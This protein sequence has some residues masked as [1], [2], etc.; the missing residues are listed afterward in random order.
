MVNGHLAIVSYRALIDGVES[1]KLDFRVLWFE[2]SDP[3]EIRELIMCK[4]LERYLNGDGQEV[5]WE[6]I[7]V[8]AVEA[9]DP[10]DSGDEVI[11]FVTSTDALPEWKEERD[12]EAD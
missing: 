5:C 1:S 8:L 7:E 12:D 3:D 11:G 4:P 6:L 2:S 9:F 10:A